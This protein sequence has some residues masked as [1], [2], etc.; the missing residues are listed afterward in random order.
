[1][2]FF[3][4]VIFLRFYNELKFYSLPRDEKMLVLGYHMVS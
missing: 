2:S 4:K 3:N 1:M